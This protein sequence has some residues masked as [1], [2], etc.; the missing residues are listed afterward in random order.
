MIGHLVDAVV[1][2]VAHP[3][4]TRGRSRDV[5]VVEAD[6]RR[7]DHAQARQARNVVRRDGGS[8]D[9]NPTT[10][11]P[12]HGGAEVSTETSSRASARRVCSSGTEASQS[13]RFI[14]AQP[15]N[16]AQTSA[17]SL[18]SRSMSGRGPTVMRTY[19]A[20]RSRSLDGSAGPARHS[21]AKDD[22][23]DVDAGE[24]EV[25]R[26]R[27]RLQSRTPHTVRERLARGRD[28]PTSRVDRLRRPQ[29]ARAP[30]ASAAQFTLNGSSRRSK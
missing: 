7:C 30:A 17:S 24:H 3:H 21:I 15:R 16:E 9:S 4:A 23:V 18:L 27:E 13:T 11:S 8:N 26:R 1:G 12:V 5:E 20:A 19:P 22:V 14:C 25:R 2:D 6:A 10:S 28:F 29:H